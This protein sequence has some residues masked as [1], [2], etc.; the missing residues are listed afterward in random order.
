M[1]FALSIPYDNVLYTVYGEV[2]TA[3]HSRQYSGILNFETSG[4]ASCAMATN[5][6]AEHIA[7]LSAARTNPYAIQVAVKICSQLKLSISGQRR[8][9]KALNDLPQIV[10]SDPNLAFAWHADHV[11]R[12]PKIHDG[13]YEHLLLTVVLAE[14]FHETYAAEVF[15]HMARQKL[16]STQSTP[17]IYQWLDLLHFC[18]GILACDDFGL[19]VEN[20]ILLDPYSVT[21][22]GKY[23]S[24]RCLTPPESLAAVLLAVGE[25][26]SGKRSQLTIRGGGVIGWIAALAEHFYDLSVSIEAKMGD[27]LHGPK[28]GAQLSLIYTDKP[29]LV[30]E[31]ATMP[32]L[33]KEVSNISLSAF[34]AQ[35]HFL[36]FGGRVTWQALLPQVFGKAYH[37]LEH[38]HAKTMYSAIGSAFAALEASKDASSIGPRQHASISTYPTPPSAS[39]LIATLTTSV[40]SLRK[41]QGRME[42]ELRASPQDAAK[43]H[44]EQIH[45]LAAACGCGICASVSGKKQDQAVN[46]SSGHVEPPTGYCLPAVVETV[47]MIG[48]LLSRIILAHP[49][50]PSREGV[51]LLYKLR[52]DKLSRT[53][54]HNSLT[55]SPNAIAALYDNLLIAPTSQILRMTVKFFAGGHLPIL[56]T[57]LLPSETVAVAHEGMCAYAAELAGGRNVRKDMKGMVRVVNG[58]FGIRQKMY[59][60]AIWSQKR[61]GGREGWQWEEVEVEHL[62]GEKGGKLWCK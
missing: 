35:I 7:D 40:A 14:C 27:H 4:C 36:P 41:G 17:H 42:K 6:L 18:N 30:I 61:P 10:S 53:Q 5:F 9:N 29:E 57:D 31:D 51:Q 54:E 11:I 47:I 44:L 3:E 8:L 12:S 46:G 33:A 20:F 59:K 39:T 58:G 24:D 45:V 19:F 60:V 16:P 34:S 38:D 49:L 13:S 25:V 21:P 62:R 22:G 56:G 26:I 32:A 23:S 55:P 50:N 1:G 52:T 28:D 43:T 48:L 15:H 2:W 37:T